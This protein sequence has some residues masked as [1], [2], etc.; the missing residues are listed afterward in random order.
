MSC[1]VLYWMMLKLDELEMVGV[2]HSCIIN[3]ADTF[4]L[5]RK[6][7]GDVVFC[8]DTDVMLFI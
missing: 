7:L 5:K 6:L 2:N 3:I 8:A 4:Q 1:Y